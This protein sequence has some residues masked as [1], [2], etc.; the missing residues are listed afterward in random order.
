VANRGGDLL[1][2]AWPVSFLYACCVEALSS[3]L[4]EGLGMLLARDIELAD[5]RY[6]DIMRQPVLQSAADQII[7]RQPLHVQLL[8][9]FLAVVRRRPCGE[10][11]H[12]FVASLRRIIVGPVMQVE[13]LNAAYAVLENDMCGSTKCKL[14]LSV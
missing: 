8:M 13:L 3:T 1:P 14:S 10:T 4:L 12:R 9:K 6:S 2:P 7:E 11:V 5:G